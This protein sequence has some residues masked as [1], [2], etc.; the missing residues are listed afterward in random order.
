MFKGLNKLNL[1]KHYCTI[2]PGSCYGQA[3]IQMERFRFTILVFIFA[4]T[5][6][7]ANT[8]LTDSIQGGRTVALQEK[9]SL[10]TRILPYSPAIALTSSIVIPGAGQVYTHQY[11]KA[12][13]FLVAEVGVGLFGYQRYIWEQGLNHEADSFEILASKNNGKM[14]IDSVKKDT[15]FPGISYQLLADKD[16][17]DAKETRFVVNQCISWGLGIYYYNV[18]DALHATKLFHDDLK[19]DPAVAGWLSAI[20]ALGLGQLYNG[21]LSKAGMIFM[22]QFNLGYLA[23]NYHLLMRDCENYE[24]SMQS[25]PHTRAA[26][27][28][29]GLNNDWENR[30]KNAFRNRNMYIWYSILFY[31]YGV[32][33]AVVDAHL[34]DAGVKM[35][36]EPDLVPI[37]KQVGM[38]MT[39][40]F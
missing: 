18:M 21:E 36:L 39:M 3:T 26:F 19:R 8:P 16:R 10:K 24:L 30:R 7:C 40:P 33:D 37:N 5:A 32:L 38:T 6:L 13:L 9:D 14:V 15:L 35:K 31:I 29:N 17:Y 27:N 1:N 34:H 4:I 23:V 11:L 12:G 22:T 2:F 25:D 28:A 20:P